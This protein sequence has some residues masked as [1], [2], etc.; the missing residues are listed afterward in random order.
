[1]AHANTTT[2]PRIVLLNA[3]RIYQILKVLARHGFGD[4]A[5]RVG[6]EGAWGGFKR[7]VSFGRWQGDDEALRLRWEERARIVFEELG[8]TYIKFGQILATRPDLIPMS[9]VHEL[10][11]LQDNVPP[12]DPAAAKQIVTEELGADVGELFQR[13]DNEPLA[14]ASIA[15]VHRAQLKNGDEVVLKIQRPGLRRIISRDLDL[16]RAFATLLEQRIPEVRRWQ[17]VAI[18]EEFDKSIHKEIDFG[19]EMH[20]IKKFAGNFAGDPD[21]YVPRVYE[22]LCTDSVLVMEYIDGIRVNSRELFERDDLDREQISKNG[23]RIILEQV[24]VHGF[25]HADPHPGNMFVLPGNVVC[26]IDFGIMGALEQERIDELLT[27]LVYLLTQNAERMVRQFQRQG[28]VTEH[29]DTRGL[30]TD[31]ADLMDRYMGVEVSRIDVATYIQQVFDVITRY[32]IVLPADLL[33]IGKALATID[34]I[35]RDIYPELDPVSAIR[36]HIMGIYF[37]RLTDPEFYTRD[38]RRALEDG[39][40]LLQRLP[41]EIRLIMSSLREGKL[42]L[43]W[44]PEEQ[45]LEYMV[46]ERNRSMNRLSFA[47]AIV[48]LAGV[49]SYL[50]VHSEGSLHLLGIAG[51]LLGGLLGLLFFYGVF[52]SG[53]Q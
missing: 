1:M 26:L 41:R 42:K 43:K 49:S 13:F 10:R 27:F 47:V 21:V 51:Y 40:L 19:R 30:R 18:V 8:A 3:P 11:K 12:F 46:R 35:T 53:G 28:L 2:L 23:I 9:L 17:P 37:K 52:R 44:E 38:T 5:D 32:D 48:G 16:L 39:L 22:D 4:I 34:G 31:L 15:Q 29:M 45:A 20:N 36:P 6:V 50:M 14:A 24:F 7:R 25:F 33:L